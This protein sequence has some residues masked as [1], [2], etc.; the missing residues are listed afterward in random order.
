MMHGHEKTD[1][2]IVAEKRANK[3]AH[4][5]V[6]QST[7]GAA[8]AEPVEPRAGTKGNTDWQSTHWTQSQVRVSQAPERIRQAIA[9]WT[10]GRSRMRESRT[11]GSGRGARESASLPLRR[12]EFIAGLGGAAVASP[13]FKVLPL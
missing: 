3:A 11:S 9:V 13:L 6:E 10:R 4:D 5:V 7:A 12:R 8:A 1:L 2:A